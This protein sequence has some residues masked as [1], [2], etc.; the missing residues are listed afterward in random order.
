MKIPE[1]RYSRLLT[2]HSYKYSWTPYYKEFTVSSLVWPNIKQLSMKLSWSHSDSE[3]VTVNQWLEKNN[4]HMS[5]LALQ[6]EF[7][8]QHGTCSHK[9]FQNATEFHFRINPMKRGHF[10]LEL[11]ER[12]KRWQHK[13]YMYQ[14]LIQR[15]G[16]F[17]PKLSSPPPSQVN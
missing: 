10:R 12:K 13:L 15:T 6:A 8:V 2:R 1:L 9:T 7:K 16:I 11:I 17:P 5:S 4:Q 14:R 3:P